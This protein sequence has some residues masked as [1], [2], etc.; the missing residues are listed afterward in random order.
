MQRT[1]SIDVITFSACPRGG[2]LSDDHTRGHASPHLVFGRFMPINICSTGM[3]S[4]SQQQPSNLSSTGRGRSASPPHA[5]C[6]RPRA[7]RGQR[8]AHSAFPRVPRAPA[9]AQLLKRHPHSPRRHAASC[10]GQSNLSIAHPLPGCL[11]VLHSCFSVVSPDPTGDESSVLLFM[12]LPS[13]A[14]FCN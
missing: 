5:R 6:A 12:L 2:T 10:C 1:K 3:C 13:F 9:C 4:V 8:P 11:R 14:H 7:G